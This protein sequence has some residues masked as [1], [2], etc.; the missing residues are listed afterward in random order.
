MASCHCPERQPYSTAHKPSMETLTWVHTIAILSVRR[1]ILCT[2]APP[3]ASISK[4]GITGLDPL[5]SPARELPAGHPAITEAPPCCLD[6]PWPF[7]ESSPTTGAWPSMVLRGMRKQRAGVQLWKGFL[8]PAESEPMLNLRE[9][10]VFLIPAVKLPILV[11]LEPLDPRG[12]ARRL[13]CILRVQ[14]VLGTVVGGHTWRL[15]RVPKA[16]HGVT[17]WQATI[18]RD[19]IVTPPILATFPPAIGVQVLCA[20][21]CGIRLEW[22]GWWW[23]WRQWRRWRRSRR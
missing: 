21:E 15:L 12:H 16:F 4:V 1:W 2:R 10:V 20:R 5:T 19:A 17:T 11:W 18:G 6:H 22:L 23:Q 13:S 8:E 3:P 14:E 7:R 9:Y